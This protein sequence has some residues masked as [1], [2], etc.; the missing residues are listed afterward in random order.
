MTLDSAGS[1][2]SVHC[3]GKLSKITICH[4]EQNQGHLSTM[5]Q[6]QIG[7]DRGLGHGKLSSQACHSPQPTFI[8]ASVC[9]SSQPTKAWPDS[10]KATTLCSSLERIL[11][12]LAVP[13]RS[14]GTVGCGHLPGACSLLA[15][16]FCSHILTVTP[17][18]LTFKGALEKSGG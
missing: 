6:A 11:L 9:S 2:C 8:T 16:P 15:W 4:S 1:F 10:W 18:N 7:K 17:L 5:R 12:F 3:F 14:Q 13:E